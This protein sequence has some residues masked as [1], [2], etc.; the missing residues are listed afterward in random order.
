MYIYIHIYIYI[1]HYVAM[2][3]QCF[4]GLFNREVSF[5]KEPYKNRALMQ[6]KPHNLHR[7]CTWSVYLYHV[8]GG[9]D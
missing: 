1:C 3:W 5:A 8:W 7:P 9:Y 4:V 6:K 2:W